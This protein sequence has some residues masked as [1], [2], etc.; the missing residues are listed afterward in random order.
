MRSHKRTAFPEGSDCGVPRHGEG[1]AMSAPAVLAP[2]TAAERH[3]RAPPRGHTAS[4][5]LGAARYLTFELGD[6]SDHIEHQLAGR[7]ARIHPDVKNPEF[8]ATTGRG[9]G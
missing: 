8:N 6:S 3:K 7:R 1:A 2:V 5:M 9:W 4:L